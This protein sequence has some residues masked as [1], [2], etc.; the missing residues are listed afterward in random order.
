[1]D[2]RVTALKMMERMFEEEAANIEEDT[3]VLTK[4][5][6]EEKSATIEEASGETAVTEKPAIEFDTT[7]E[8]AT[9]VLTKNTDEEKSATV[10]EAAA[11]SIKATNEEKAATKFEAAT[12]EAAKGF[13]EISTEE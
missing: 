2:R 5:T 9:K 3:K 10:E 6:D 7:E 11:V 1:M 12:E 4:N 8:D 13:T